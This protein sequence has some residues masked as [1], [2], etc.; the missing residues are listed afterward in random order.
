MLSFPNR[1]TQA[2]SRLRDISMADLTDPIPGRAPHLC[3]PQLDRSRIAVSGHHYLK[4]GVAGF[5]HCGS[6]RDSS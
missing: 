2:T 5:G 4:A 3:N 6:G 1:Y